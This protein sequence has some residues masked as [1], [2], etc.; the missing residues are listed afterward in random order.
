MAGETKLNQETRLSY[1]QC[2]TTALPKLRKFRDQF[3]G[4]SA[5]RSSADASTEKT[6][7]SDLD[8]ACKD[9]MTGLKDQVN[10]M[11]GLLNGYMKQARAKERA[12]A[13]AKAKSLAAQEATPRV[14]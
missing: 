10:G 11:R 12:A 3:D 7:F 1:E 8:T 13:K 4:I 14:I 9:L 6:A 2:F 5:G